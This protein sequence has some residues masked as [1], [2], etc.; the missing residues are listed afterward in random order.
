MTG[1]RQPEVLSEGGGRS[2]VCDTEYGFYRIFLFLYFW[3]LRAG[4]VLIYL[5]TLAFGMGW[6]VHSKALL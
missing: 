4:L 6:A 3:S 5:E 2:N 1:H